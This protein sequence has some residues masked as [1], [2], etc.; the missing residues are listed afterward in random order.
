MSGDRAFLDTNLFVYLY[1]DND[2]SKKKCVMDAIDS[3][4]SFVSTQVLNEFCNVCIRKLKLSPSEVRNAV[5][6]IRR[7]CNLVIVD[8]ATTMSALELHERYG[9]SYYDS[10][11]AVSALESDCQYLLTED[12]SD[13][14]IIEGSLQGS[15]TVKN[16]FTNS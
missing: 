5:I 3:Y 2:A 13:G 10:L 8:D 12:M 6:E 15:L 1:S 11:I 16:I 7:A 4:D 9:Y 14:Q